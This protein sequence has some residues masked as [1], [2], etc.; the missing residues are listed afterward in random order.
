M[1]KLVFVL[2]ILLAFSV[3]AI[4]TMTLEEFEVQENLENSEETA[5]IKEGLKNEKQISIRFSAIESFPFSILPR[6]A[7]SLSFVPYKFFELTVNFSVPFFLP[8]NMN[9]GDY[10]LILKAGW[11]P[12]IDCRIVSREGGHGWVFRFPMALGVSF[13]KWNHRHD[14]YSM[15]GKSIHL[16]FLPGFEPVYMIN[17]LFGIAIPIL[18][19]VDVIV[20]YEDKFDGD[21]DE[22]SED[23]YSRVNLIIETGVGVV[24]RF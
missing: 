23:P 5:M 6:A 10:S 2:T 16:L 9:R 11:V 1:K 17:K 3:N 15:I 8:D 13:Y 20:A 21:E 22:E 14:S 24:F 4:E 19:G 18:I 7:F 12:E